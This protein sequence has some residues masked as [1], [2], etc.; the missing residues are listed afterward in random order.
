MVVRSTILYRAEYWPIKNSYIEKIKTVKIKML[1]WIYGHTMLDK[2]RNK[3]ILL[4]VGV[5]PVEKK[6]RETI[7]RWFGHVQGRS[8]YVPVRR[9]KRMALM[10]I[11][12]GLRRSK[13]Y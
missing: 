12:R 9:C 13:K 8:S 6:I 2:I 5:A 3:D 10:G 1:R 7:M 11:R 4:K